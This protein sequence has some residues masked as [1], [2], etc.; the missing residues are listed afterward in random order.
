MGVIKIQ[1]RNIVAMTRSPGLLLSFVLCFFLPTGCNYFRDM[2]VQREWVREDLSR[3]CDSFVP[4]PS[5]KKVG[6]QEVIKPEHGTFTN[7]FET[8]MDCDIA[9]KPFYDFLISSGWEPTRRDS[10]YYY[11][12]NY[13]VSVSCRA[14][15]SPNDVKTVS[16]ICSWDK[17]GEKKELLK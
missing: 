13:V 11:R 7:I 17:D 9:R 4:P 10:P 12:E 16:L 15:L 3:L 6:T 5:L 8:E 1:F 14:G 2:Q